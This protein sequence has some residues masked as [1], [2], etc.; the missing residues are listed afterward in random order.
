MLKEWRT[1]SGIIVT[2]ILGGRSNVFLITHNNRHILVDTSPGRKWKALQ[3]KLLSLG[4]TGIDYLV[5]THTHFDHAGNAAKIRKTFQAKIMVH[6]NEADNLTKGMNPPVCGTGP[7]SRIIVSLF[8][9]RAARL[10]RYEGCSIDYTVDSEYSLREPE[11]D[12]YI[13]HTP[14]HTQGS[15]SVI[16]D[17]EIAIV[18]DAMFGVF[19]S[20]VFPPFAEDITGLLNSWQRL[21][22]TGCK[23]FLPSHGDEKTSA[24]LAS[25]LKKMAHRAAR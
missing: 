23:L 8:I 12:A 7:F 14:G 19:S 25:C 11:I 6:K 17:N 1:T 18:G 22:D 5:L 24:Q 20:S 2:R 13:I 10:L 9:K 21:L 3:R 16:I 15:V 4:I